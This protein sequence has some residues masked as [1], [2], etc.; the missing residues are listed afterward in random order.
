LSADVELR[1]TIDLEEKARRDDVARLQYAEEK[2]VAK[3]VAK[4]RVEQK[5][6]IALSMLN[7]KISPDMIARLTGLSAQEI[8]SLQQ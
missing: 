6:E 2:G 3:G 8:Q 4:G 5:R 7:E 1:R